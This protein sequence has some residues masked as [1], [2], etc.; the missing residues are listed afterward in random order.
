[1]RFIIFTLT[2][3]ISTDVLSQENQTDT[4]VKAIQNLCF[5]PSGK[6]NY[7]A[8]EANA[9]A[10]ARIKLLGKLSGDIK[11]NK[12]EW[13]G[14]RRVLPKDQVLDSNKYRDCVMKLTPTFI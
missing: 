6:G 9:N 2:L 11:L 1:M 3:L 12:E 10:G 5:H 8:I 14:V 7:W 13:D 4:L